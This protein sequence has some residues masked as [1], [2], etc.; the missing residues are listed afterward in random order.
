MATENM[1][2]SAE[3]IHRRARQIEERLKRMPKSKK[4]ELAKDVVALLTM[5]SADKTETVNGSQTFE[6]S[7]VSSG[8]WV[9]ELAE[10]P[11]LLV[12]EAY[13]S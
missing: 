12:Q 7:R 3:E 1:I 10:S 11:I 6:P 5:L 9:E 4:L 13:S 2:Q 8:E